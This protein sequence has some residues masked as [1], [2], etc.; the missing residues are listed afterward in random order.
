MQDLSKVTL[1][2]IDCYNY[3]GAVAS[4]QK[5]MEQ[6]NFGAVKFL[7]DIDI[8]IDNVE[9]V[10]IPTISSKEEYSHFCI[11]ELNKYFDTDFVLVTQHDSWVL[12]GNS[13]DNDFF[14]YDYIGAPWLYIDGRNVGN[15]GFSL[16]SKK[17]QDILA[18]DSEIKISSP[19]DEIIGR[20]YRNYLQQ[21][22]EIEFAP[23]YV[24]E[25]FSFELKEPNQ[26]T[27]GFHGYFHKPYKPTIVLKRS[28]ALGDILIAE[29]LFR[30]FY[31]KDYNVV[32]D[33][34]IFYFDLFSNHYFPI[35][36][37]SQIDIGRIKPEKIVNLD[38]AYEVKPKQN[39]LKSYFEFCGI[40]DYELSRPILYP[41][42]NQ[43]TKLF[44]PYIVIHIDE[45]DTPHR[46]I[47]G[48][49]WKKV[50]KCI[51]SYG[52]LLIQVG[53]QKHEEVGIEINT[54]SLGFLKFV[55]AGCD[56]FLGIDSAPLGIA[57][58]YNKPCV[59]FFGSVNPE[60]IHPDLESLEVIQQP[61][62]HQH[63]WHSK[64]GGTEGVKC[65]F[66]ELEPPC[67]VS[68]TKQ[69]INAI[70]KLLKPKNKI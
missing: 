31:E 4:L 9:V 62:V 6:C 7:T 43:Q 70:N 69:I 13:W 52:Y 10:Q 8:D 1:I 66:N 49:D 46:N 16:R 27:F 56:M 40:K 11:K 26:K 39:Y 36:H 29:P 51:E 53:R 30:Y 65:V 63:C 28:A 24:A 18:N 68:E 42:V 17:L 22:Y 14:N 23:E 41:L 2:A 5:S 54:S 21:T 37:I 64:V 48:V 57:M 45:R 25:K 12:D 3:G 50:K 19:E 32:L 44:K 55:I 61:C 38:L 15:G 20:F 58:A 35:K 60:Y 47:Y 59:G 67:C 34:P 33:I